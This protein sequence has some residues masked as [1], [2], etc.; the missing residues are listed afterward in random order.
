MSLV[1]AKL[2]NL[3]ISPRK[4][5]LVANLIKGMSVGNAEIELQIRSRRST[6]PLLKLLRS[7]KA[8]AAHQGFSEHDLRIKDIRVDEGVSLKRARKQAPGRIKQVVKRSSHIRV[9]LE[10]G[11]KLR[12]G[13]EKILPSRTLPV[14]SE[15]ESM[16]G[17]LG[18]E[19]TET[20]MRKSPRPDQVGKI[21]PL[22][23]GRDFVKR[24]FRRKAI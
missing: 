13:L 15:E 22:N 23:R 11:E 7:A 24:V 19:T 16:G 20:P 21:T 17:A 6:L 3:R 12:S 9:V 5:R 4:V 1:I 10:T 8:N 14:K 2:S 18:G